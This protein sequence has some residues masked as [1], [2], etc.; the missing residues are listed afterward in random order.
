MANYKRK[1]SR[2]DVRCVNCTDGRQGNSMADGYGRSPKILIDKIKSKLALDEYEASEEIDK[3]LAKTH[4]NY[5]P[6]E[7]DE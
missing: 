5:R 1:K 7:E 2:K 6:D 4:G 3:N